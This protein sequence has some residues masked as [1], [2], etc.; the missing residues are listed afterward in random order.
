MKL[1]FRE[2]RRTDLGNRGIHSG[3]SGPKINIVVFGGDFSYPFFIRRSPQKLYS[4]RGPRFFSGHAQLSWFALAQTRGRVCSFFLKKVGIWLAGR[5]PSYAN[6]P[7][8]SWAD[9]KRRERK[10]GREKREQ[11]CKPRPPPP[12]PQQ[13]RRLRQSDTVVRKAAAATREKKSQK[14]EERNSTLDFN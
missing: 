3:L 11:K 12:P 6:P 1:S 5:E 13:T 9:C 2:I 10:R 8:K 14:C 7:Q 4:S